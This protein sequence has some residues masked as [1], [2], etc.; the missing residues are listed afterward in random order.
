MLLDVIEPIEEDPLAA[1]MRTVTEFD[2][3][4]LE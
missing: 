3:L 4:S 2:I 1:A